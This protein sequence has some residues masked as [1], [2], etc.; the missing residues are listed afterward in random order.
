MPSYLLLVV[1]RREPRVCLRLNACPRPR[2]CPRS[3][4]EPDHP[5]HT[6]LPT[7]RRS[8]LKAEGT[9]ICTPPGSRSNQMPQKGVTPYPHTITD[10]KSPYPRESESN[11][12]T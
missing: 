10:P 9:P 12:S 2:E 3:A 1:L 8:T 4:T 5:T 11:K 7:R 6:R